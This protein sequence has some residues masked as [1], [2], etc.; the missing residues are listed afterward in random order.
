MMWWA[1][2][3]W[4]GDFRLVEDPN[5]KNVCQLLIMQPTPAELQLLRTFLTTARKKRWTS[6]TIK[7]DESILTRTISLAAPLTQVGPALVKVV[8]PKDRTLTAVSFKDGRL[9]VAETGALETLVAKV[10]NETAK[11]AVSV[12]RPTPCC[13]QCEPGSIGPA[14]EVLQAFLTPQEH[15]DWAKHR[16]IMIT[17]GLSGHRYLLAHR[18]SRTAVRNGKICYDL[19]D[20]CILHFHASDVPPEEEVLAA[21]LILE[22]R[23]PWL[24]NE[25]TVL[26]QDSKTGRWFSLGIDHYKNPFGDAGDGRADAA[27]TASFGQV[28]Q[29]AWLLAKKIKKAEEKFHGQG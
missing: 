19:D 26:Q 2:P 16:A 10:S 6:E 12:A 8:K 29:I 20:H 28:V 9:E 13:P 22:H 17:G 14:R 1:F 24:R 21:K 11:A 5:D 15:E 25:A 4:N 27:L 23:E 18:H 7:T 3:S